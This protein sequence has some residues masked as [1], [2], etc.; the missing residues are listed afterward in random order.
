MGRNADRVI[1]H[2]GQVNEANM[3]C[4]GSGKGQQRVVGIGT[5]NT[6]AFCK[7]RNGKERRR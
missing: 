5:E 7:Q 6:Q 4:L 3:T 2:V 1:L